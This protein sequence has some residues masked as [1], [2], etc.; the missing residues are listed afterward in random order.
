MNLPQKRWS[1]Q[2]GK[3]RAA[4]FL[5]DNV[6]YSGEDCLTWPFC[7]MPTGYGVLGYLRKNHYAHRFMCE[8]VNGPPPSPVHEAAHSCGRGKFGCVDPRHLSW[9]TP[10][11]NALDSREHGTQARNPWGAA[12]KL[13]R[14]Q[15]AEIWALK[16]RETQEKI[17]ARFGM[18]ASTIRDIYL[19]RTHLG[20]TVVAAMR[21]LSERD[22]GGMKN[23]SSGLWSR[24]NLEAMIDDLV[25]D[26]N[27][28]FD[29]G[30]SRSDP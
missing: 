10:T 17:A 16:G 26:T 3:G 2:R 1:G 5:H 19:G 13:S 24:Q 25:V 23:Y 20:M 8:L 14:N 12:G 30:Q 7:T 9:K 21:K 4:A 28:P 27:R 11:A 18:S 6:N 15:I 22:L 29:D